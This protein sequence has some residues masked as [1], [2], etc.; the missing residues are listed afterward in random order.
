MRDWPAMVCVAVLAAFAAPARSQ[1]DDA[2]VRRQMLEA[3]EAGEFDRAH[4][5]ARGIIEADP[6]D[7]R[8][9]YNLALILARMGDDDGS[10][11]ALIDAIQYGF[12]DLHA[13]ERDP[14]LARVRTTGKYARVVERWGV[15]LD[16]VA[17]AKFTDTKS[18]LG[19][20]YRESRDAGARL[21]WLSV[22]EGAG[23]EEARREAGRVAAWCAERGLFV[24]AEAARPDPWVTV[25][26]P[27]AED[28]ADL[29]PYAMV[30]GTYSRDDKRLVT[31]DLGPT[32]RHEFFH[33]LHWRDMDR[34]GQV[35][36]IWVQEGMASLLEDV[37]I[38][39]DGAYEIHP[40]WRTNVAKRLER[41]GSLRPLEVLIATDRD[42]FVSHRPSANYAHARALMMF[43]ESRG[44][45]GDFYRAL[46]AGFDSDPTGVV[47]LE[48]A[49][50]MPIA[51]A[52]RSFRKW[53]GELPEV[54]ERA[55]PPDA[56]LGVGV[57][58]GAGEAPMVMLGGGDLRP[59]SLL[60]AGDVIVSIDGRSTATL[61]DL[62]RVL[63]DYEP[64]DEVAV[65]VERGG[66]RTE[67]RVVLRSREHAG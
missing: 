58:P 20:A 9:R 15:L 52:E 34:A 55:H 39:R 14:G 21:L 54:G 16:A 45:L 42:R 12:V 28:F 30:G 47:A 32:L 64:G 2:D 23:F 35:H 8:T 65:R 26:I 53:L 27:T 24:E 4:G 3:F 6:G 5:I 13:M 60:R 40:S 19:P 62:Y 48:V 10:V 51:D 38:G 57:A 18:R 29:V 1:T 37:E 17:Q 41:S 66:E 31:R 59:G 7:W 36:P 33:V 25:I 11:E 67:V 49:L 56:G 63:G 61:D 46:R 22:V 44:A 50:G 43:L